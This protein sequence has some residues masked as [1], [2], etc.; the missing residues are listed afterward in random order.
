MTEKDD[1]G[2]GERNKSKV[3]KHPNQLIIEIGS[4]LLIWGGLVK[5]IESVFM[6]HKKEFGKCYGM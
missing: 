3:H 5:A 6:Y 1:P 2:I 4:I